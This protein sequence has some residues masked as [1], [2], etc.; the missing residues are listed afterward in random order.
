MSKIESKK[1]VV[2]APAEKVFS[3]LSNMNNIKELLPQDK[4]TEWKS[5]DT[6][7]SFKIQGA[8]TIGLQFA[9]SKPHSE[10]VYNSTAGSPFPFV[11]NVFMS[12]QDSSTEGH[13]ICDAQI[14]PFLE[15]MVKGPLKNL[16]DYMA[17]K[18]TQKVSA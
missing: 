6:E 11:L 16:F 3:F 10:I 13:M 8:Y 4:I 15:M 18:L 17:D 14:N 1:V 2:N 9:S 7:C 5:S 12:E